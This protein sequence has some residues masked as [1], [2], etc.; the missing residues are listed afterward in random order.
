MQATVELILARIDGDRLRYLV[1]RHACRARTDP[2]TRARAAMTRMFRGVSLR[3]AVVH[4][5]SWR[6]EAKVLILTYLGYSDELPLRE[7]PLLLPPDAPVTGTEI[8]A[9]TAHAVR[10][11]AFLSHH[12]AVVRSRLSPEALPYLDRCVPALAGRIYGGRAA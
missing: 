11:L 9:V 5:T 6:Y 2:D 10:H 3:R 4:S 8:S 1:T 12:D 7:L